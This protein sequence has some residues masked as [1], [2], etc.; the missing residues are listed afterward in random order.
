MTTNP[1]I[2]LYPLIDLGD[3]SKLIVNP[4]DFLG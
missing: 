1:D 2:A 3:F 4:Q